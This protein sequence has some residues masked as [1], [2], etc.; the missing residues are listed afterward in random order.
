MSS[1]IKQAQP[2]EHA[3]ADGQVPATGPGQAIAQAQAT[4]QPD[5]LPPMTAE[6]ARRL[7]A[8][9]A[10]HLMAMRVVT[11]GTPYGANTE[12]A[13]SA[14]LPPPSAATRI[15]IAGMLER[16]SA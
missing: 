16:I 12:P 15:F 4:E 14:Q 5:Q 1:G 2:F 8:L 9:L 7:A 10:P 3:L 6:S 11:A 13:A